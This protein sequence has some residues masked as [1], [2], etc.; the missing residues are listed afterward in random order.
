MNH[1]SFKELLIGILYNKTDNYS[2]FD[3][4][5]F[6]NSKKK[7]YSWCNI[8]GHTSCVH[9]GNDLDVLR[10]EQQPKSRRVLKKHCL[11]DSPV[12]DAI[13]CFSDID[14]KRDWFLFEYDYFNRPDSFRLLQRYT[15]AWKA[16]NQDIEIIKSKKLWH[17]RMIS[18]LYFRG[19]KKD[20]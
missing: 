15:F 9:T 4:I 16:R 7:Q 13:Y 10:Y 14:R 3:R 5:D 11:V 1:I 12:N 8:G 20:K 6:W 18:P 2:T 17:V 19:D